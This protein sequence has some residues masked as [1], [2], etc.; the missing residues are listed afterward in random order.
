MNPKNN[1]FDLLNDVMLNEVKEDW[2]AYNQNDK[3]IIKRNIAKAKQSIGNT[4][5]N[6]SLNTSSNVTRPS[7]SANM[8]KPSLSPVVQSKNV[9]P[10]KSENTT[11]MPFYN[12]NNSFSN[13]KSK[14][15]SQS[16]SGE[17]ENH[18]SSNKK[19]MDPNF[20]LQLNNSKR[21]KPTT[22][23]VNTVKPVDN[24]TKFINEFM[25]LIF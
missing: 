20:D 9:S 7:L 10:T 2:P 15:P 1:Q 17:T 12:G 22:N 25:K 8:N 4:S 23:G 3:Q 11:K 19:A 5:L 13:L 16:P 18:D 14:Y 6:N 21:L 24:A